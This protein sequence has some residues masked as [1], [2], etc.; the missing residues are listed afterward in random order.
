MNRYAHVYSAL[1]QQ[2][3]CKLLLNCADKGSHLPECTAPSKQKDHRRDDCHALL[4]CTLLPAIHGDGKW[5]PGW[6]YDISGDTSSIGRCTALTASIR[7]VCQTCLGRSCTQRSAA[8]CDHLRCNPLSNCTKR[9]GMK[10]AESNSCH[11]LVPLNNLQFI[12]VIARTFLKLGY[13]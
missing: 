4:R 13:G 2:F 9:N 6:L 10:R 7:M 5:D 11:V 1:S 8:Q 3:N 12:N